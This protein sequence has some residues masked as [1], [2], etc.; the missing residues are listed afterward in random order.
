MLNQ[1]PGNDVLDVYDN[2]KTPSKNTTEKKRQTIK[3]VKEM[4]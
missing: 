3:N 1:K 2:A 4:L